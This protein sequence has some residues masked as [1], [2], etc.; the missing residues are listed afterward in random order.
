MLSTA[1]AA[2]LISAGLETWQIGLC[3]T[4]CVAYLSKETEAIGGIMISASHN[5]PED[6]GIKF[7]SH[8]GKKLAKTATQQIEA[9]LRDHLCAD[10]FLGWGQTKQRHELVKSLQSISTQ[11]FTRNV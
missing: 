7:F 6:N 10:I 2:G 11:H 3:P 1:I 4:P 8:E 5:P 9:G